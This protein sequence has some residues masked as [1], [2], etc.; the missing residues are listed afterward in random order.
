CG[1][2]LSTHSFCSMVLVKSKGGDGATRIDM[3]RSRCSN[4]ANLG[5]AAAMNSSK[6]SPCTNMPLICPVSPCPDIV[7]K[8][9]LKR[10]IRA[11]HPTANITVYKTHYA[12]AENEKT[13]LKTISTAKTR[14]SSKTH[15][16]IRISPEH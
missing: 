12:L 10:H 16:N 6:R 4:L 15:I 5:L 13:A 1:F 3:T 7:W 2:C 11:V 8:Y 9:N 14:K